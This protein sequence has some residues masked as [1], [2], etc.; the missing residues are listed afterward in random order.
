M[1]NRNEQ[2]GQFFDSV[3]EE[4]DIKHLEHIGGIKKS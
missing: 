1:K 2:V 4:Y 3:A